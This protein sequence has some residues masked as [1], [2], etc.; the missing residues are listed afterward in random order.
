MKDKVMIWSPA[1]DGFSITP[2]SIKRGKSVLE[3]SGYDVHFDS[4]A[5]RSYETGV[6]SKV[7]RLN[8]LKQLNGNLEKIVLMSTYGGYS[9][10]LILDELRLIQNMKNVIL[11]G[12]S[13]LTCILNGIYTKYNI[14]SIYGIDFSKICNPYLEE[15]DKNN[16][17]S[18]LAL[19]DI[20]FK[21]QEKFNDGF[22]YLH[23]PKNSFS[24]KWEVF[25]E[26]IGR[27]ITGISVG[28]NMESLLTLA[29]TEYMPNFT[30]KI[31]VLETI[32][33][34]SV[35]QFVMQ[36]KAMVMA[37]NICKARAIIFG[38]FEP[39]SCLNEKKIIDFILS[40][41]KTQ[42]PSV[43]S[44]VDFSHTEP[45]Y[46]FYIGGKIKLDIMKNEI[47]ISWE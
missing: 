24:Y 37:T 2:D 23:P 17:L 36:L 41:I 40:E 20:I 12:K 44:N 34:I 8:V 28:G 10:N 11:S 38:C 30:N 39:G 14:K 9:A 19:K 4:N 6:T 3:L 21:K 5:F 18:A 29:G 46:P 7:S 45:S 16:I 13:D 15:S 27:E 35:G 22:W 26:S 33:D 1:N 32:P 25:G 31:V 43:I 42:L 47:T